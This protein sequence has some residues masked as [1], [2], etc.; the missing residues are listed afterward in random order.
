M[1]PCTGTSRNVPGYLLCKGIPKQPPWLIGVGNEVA[2]SDV[3]IDRPELNGLGQYEFGWSDSDA[4]GASA[5]R[6]INEEV[7]ADISNLKNEPASMLKNRLK[8]LELFRRKP[9]PT[10]EPTSPA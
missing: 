7:V 5:R 10:W 3:L 1:T 2:M 9:M 8:G 6:G 4:A